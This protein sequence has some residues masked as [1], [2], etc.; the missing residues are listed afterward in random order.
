MELREFLARVEAAGELQTI[1]GA[2]WNLEIG[3]ITEVSA[4]FADSKA[5]LFDQITGYP[6][7][8]RVLT[9]GLGSQ[10]RSALAL[11]LDPSLSGVALVRALSENSRSSNR[12][13]R[14]G[15]PAARFLRTSIPAIR[16]TS[17]SFRLP[18]GIAKT[19]GDDTLRKKFERY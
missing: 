15:F 16:S 12:R 9:N 10:R 17:L 8:Y 13:Y 2:N 14:S 19:A 5:L 11:D 18:S 1:T 3:A 7:G 6:K 4:S